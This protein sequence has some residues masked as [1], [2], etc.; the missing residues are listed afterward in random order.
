MVVG[1]RPMPSTAELICF[2]LLHPQM[3]ST[4]KPA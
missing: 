4:L 3:P 2:Q 1:V